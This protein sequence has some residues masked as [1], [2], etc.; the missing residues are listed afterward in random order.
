[1][2]LIQI[3]LTLG[4]LIFAALAAIFS[5]LIWRSNITMDIYE[6]ERE[7]RESFEG[8]QYNMHMPESA[9]VVSHEITIERIS[10]SENRTGFIHRVRKRIYGSNGDTSIKFRV[11]QTLRD[12]SG[13]PRRTGF[14]DIYDELLDHP[15]YNQGNVLAHPPQGDGII[16][17]IYSSEPDIVEKEVINFLETVEAILTSKHSDRSVMIKKTDLK[18]SK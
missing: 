5:F 13:L 6:Q 3:G 17:D 9:N 12:Q 10:C 15:S 14:P 1:M 8:S 18:H 4:S 7:L 2:S 11:I 16:I